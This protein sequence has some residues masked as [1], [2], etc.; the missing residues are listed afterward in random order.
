M[1]TIRKYL[2]FISMFIGGAGALLIWMFLP[3]QSEIEEVWW[4][5]VKFIAFAFI[6]LGISLFPNKLRH[7]HLLVCLPFIVFLSYIIPRLSFCGIFGTITEPVEQGKFYTILYLLCYPL[8]VMSVS[9]AY[10]MGGG[11]SGKTIKINIVGMLLIFSGLLDLCFNTAN[12]R[13]LATSLDYAYHIITI[14][15][16]APT[17]IEGLIF[18]LCHVPIIILVIF[19]PLETWFEKWKLVS[20]ETTGVTL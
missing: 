1:N 19:L 17:W 6:V 8:I 9:F 14:L 7:G 4:L 18:A 13:P 20:V 15:G 10:R 11:S 5:I 12:G 16:R 3:H 2:W